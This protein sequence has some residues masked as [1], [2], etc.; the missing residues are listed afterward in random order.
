MLLVYARLHPSLALQGRVC[1]PTVG[2]MVV[3]KPAIE[4]LSSVPVYVQLASILRQQIESGQLQPD[5]PI[6]SEST[7][8]QEYGVA[9]GTA[10]KAVELLRE[11]GLVVTVRGRGTYVRPE[12]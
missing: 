12:T 4:P 11:H 5:R 2:R 6:P 10:R 8:R 1:L 9:R 7:L 3:K